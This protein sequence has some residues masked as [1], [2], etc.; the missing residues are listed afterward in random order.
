M[1]KIRD[2]LQPIKFRLAIFGLLCGATV[3]SLVLFRVRT[4][5]SG[6]DDFAFLIWN[7]FLAWIPLGIAYAASVFARR[8]RFLLLT[9]PFTAALWLIFFPNAPYILT[10]L[11]HL[12]KMGPDVPMWFDMLLLIWFAWT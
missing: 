4:V 12:G 6:S 5:L 7:I 3:A 10:D 1:K 2:T 8:R 11:L 9:I